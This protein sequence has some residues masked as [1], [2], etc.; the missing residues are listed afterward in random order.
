LNFD[1]GLLRNEI[2]EWI[3]SL[4]KALMKVISETVTRG[5]TEPVLQNDV[6]LDVLNLYAL[7]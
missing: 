1:F 2:N 7:F 5:V 6:N 3:L 4:I